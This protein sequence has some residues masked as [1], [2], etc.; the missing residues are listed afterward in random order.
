MAESRRY[1]PAQNL[2]KLFSKFFVLLIAK[3][4]PGPS[5]VH[6]G[7]QSGKWTRLLICAF[8]QSLFLEAVGF[9]AFDCLYAQWKF[10]SL[11]TMGFFPCFSFAT[12]ERVLSEYLEIWQTLNWYCKK[13]STGGSVRLKSVKSCGTTRSLTWPRS[14]PLGLQVLSPSPISYFCELCLKILR[15]MSP[16]HNVCCLHPILYRLLLSIKLSWF[17]YPSIYI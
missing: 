15:N 9:H 1:L 16:W 12:R 3:S 11:S 4:H 6:D 13:H 10:S 7:D 5:L 17:L 8:C 14:H 2:G